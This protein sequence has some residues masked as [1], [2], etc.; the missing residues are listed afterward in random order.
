MCAHCVVFVVH[1]AYILSNKAFTNQVIS[2]RLFHADLCLLHVV[3][4]CGSFSR[5]T[6]HVWVLYLHWSHNLY[7]LLDRPSF[8]YSWGVSMTVVGID[9][10]LGSSSLTTVWPARSPGSVFLTTMIEPKMSIKNL[11]TC[12]GSYLFACL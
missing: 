4:P 10:M 6:L 12:L 9:L 3:W 11:G 2:E 5:H 7:S 8:V 1:H